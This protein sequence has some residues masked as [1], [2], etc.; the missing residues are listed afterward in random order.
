MTK[1]CVCIKE[2][3]TV[4]NILQI[5]RTTTHNGFAVVSNEGGH[6]RGMMLRNQLIKL[7]QHDRFSDQGLD[8]VLSNGA[9]N[10]LPRTGYKSGELLPL[11]EFCPTLQSKNLPLEPLQTLQ[12]RVDENTVLDSRPYMNIAPVT[13]S[14]NCPII[15]CYQL[16]R[17]MGIRHLPVVND[18]NQVLGMI[19]RKELMTDFQQDLY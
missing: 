15:R 12:N 14:P 16:F 8:K 2:V 19:T 10:D 1:P 13:V 17:G 7:L 11:E 18:H 6:F 4:H 5:L 9:G 3:D